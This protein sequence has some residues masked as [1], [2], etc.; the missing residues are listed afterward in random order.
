MQEA[1]SGIISL[2]GVDHLIMERVLFFLYTVDYPDF[3]LHEFD[4]I[5]VTQLTR[6]QAS[7]LLAIHAQVYAMA[8][9]LDILE[10]R[11]ASTR[12]FKETFELHSPDNFAAVVLD[13]SATG[14]GP[15]ARCLCE[16]RYMSCGF[17]EA[18][19]VKVLHLWPQEVRLIPQPIAGPRV[20]SRE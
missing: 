10:L 17:T 5:D 8:D 11:Q 19:C 16:P 3:F 13:V 4:E 15:L 7:A 14:F 1:S 2:E 6:E 12:K 9:R 18:Y 20:H